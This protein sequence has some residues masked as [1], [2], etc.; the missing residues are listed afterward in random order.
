VVRARR[1][2]R[3]RPYDAGVSPFWIWMQALIVLCVIASIV[4]ATVKLA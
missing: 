4:I 2:R 3:R 1:P